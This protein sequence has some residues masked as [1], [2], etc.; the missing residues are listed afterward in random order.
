M[1]W[2]NAAKK[3]PPRPAAFITL[4]D[5]SGSMTFTLIWTNYSDPPNSQ[6]GRLQ[7]D[8]TNRITRGTLHFHQYGT[9]GGDI[10]GSPVASVDNVPP[11]SA[12]QFSMGTDN[13]GCLIY[14]DSFE[15]TLEGALGTK[16]QFTFRVPR[17]DAEPAWFDSNGCPMVKRRSQRTK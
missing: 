15:M 14:L 6:M 16:H 4:T 10:I 2:L 3:P 5:G 11:H 17:E 8:T 1:P 9:P 7:N 12:V 13:R